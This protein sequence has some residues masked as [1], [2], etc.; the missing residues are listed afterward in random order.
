MAQPGLCHSFTL[1]DD[2]PSATCSVTDIDPE[3]FHLRH[4]LLKTCELRGL[5]PEE[6]PVPSLGG[7][8]DFTS[9]ESTILPLLCSMTYAMAAM[10]KA[11]EELRLQTSDLEVRVANS[12]PDVTNH[13]TQLIQIQSSLRDLSHRVAHL[14]PAQVIAAPQAQSSRQHPSTVP[15]PPT[16]RT[17]GAP[18]QAPKGPTPLFVAI[19][20]GTSKFDEAAHDNMAAKMNN[21]G[22]KSPSA[23]TSAMKVVDASKKASS[24]KAIPPLASA[25]RRLFAPR[26][27]PAPQPDPADIKTHLPDLAASVL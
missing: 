9:A 2:L 24:P 19:V 25:A 3:D 21:R 13:S 23:N 27:S 26:S 12:L 14:P 6:R 16:L 15:T 11:M 4:F 8:G 1:M 20:G 5:S 7:I 17:N 10:G 18:P 22:K